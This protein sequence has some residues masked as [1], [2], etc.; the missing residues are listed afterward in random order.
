MPKAG[1]LVDY[2]PTSFRSKTPSR[3]SPDDSDPEKRDKRSDR[4][5]KTSSRDSP[6]D[7]MI[8][9]QVAEAPIAVRTC[10]I[11]DRPAIPILI[12]EHSEHTSVLTVRNAS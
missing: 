4:R 11:R 2:P 7:L 8:L 1:H 5:K 10:L 9:T 12:K 6:V 3:G